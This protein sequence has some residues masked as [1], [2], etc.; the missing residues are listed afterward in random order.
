MVNR[1]RKRTKNDKV[2]FLGKVGLVVMGGMAGA[3]LYHIIDNHVFD[4]GVINS[5]V[6]QE[7]VVNTADSETVYSMFKSGAEV[8][9]A[10]LQEAMATDYNGNREEAQAVVGLCKDIVGMEKDYIKG[11]FASMPVLS[12]SANPDSLSL[13]MKLIAG[14]KVAMVTDDL[15]GAQYMVTQTEIL[16]MAK[17][18][19]YPM[20]NEE[21]QFV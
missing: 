7:Q 11:I 3:G 13:E 8:N 19:L 4:S 6:V 5:G 10:G 17:L 21:F 9:Y 16:D 12:G 2:G 18:G 1:S 15:S 20:P 14:H